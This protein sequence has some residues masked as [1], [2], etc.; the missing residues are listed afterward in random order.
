MP[1]PGCLLGRREREVS[2]LRSS[3]DDGQLPDLPSWAMEVGCAICWFCF[4]LQ[5]IKRPVESGKLPE[6]KRRFRL[7]E[8][9]SSSLCRH[10]GLM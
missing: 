3:L 8:W 7:F 1:H 4:R 6:K 2:K 10:C 5:Q 9:C